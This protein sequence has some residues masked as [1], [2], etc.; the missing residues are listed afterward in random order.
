[1]TWWSTSVSDNSRSGVRI[2][3]RTPQLATNIEWLRYREFKTKW[4][5]R[6][7]MIVKLINFYSRG[8]LLK[9]C[10]QGELLSIECLVSVSTSK[11][12]SLNLQESIFLTSKIFYW[13][14]RFPKWFPRHFFVKIDVVD[15]IWAEINDKCP[16]WCISTP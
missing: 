2:P 11:Y 1:M 12:I 3:L 13:L 4:W 6:W 8:L 16:K 15:A 7:Q 14:S 9:H 5:W 10:L